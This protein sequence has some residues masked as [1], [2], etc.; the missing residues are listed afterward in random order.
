MAKGISGI[1]AMWADAKRELARV[2]QADPV[3]PHEPRDG[4]AP[5]RWPGF[6]WSRLPPGCRVHPLGIDGKVTYFVDSLGQ[7]YSVAASEW[8]KKTLLQLFAADPSFPYWAWPRWGAPTADRPSVINGLEVD[9]A[10]QCL[11]HAAGRRGMF[12]ADGRVRGR[13]A[14]LTAGGEFLWHAGETLYRVKGKA[15]EA[16]APS[17]VEGVL[18]PIRPPVTAPWSEPVGPEDS[19]AGALLATLRTWNWERPTLDPLLVLGWLGCA[20]SGGALK[21]RPHLFT[22][23]D[24]GVGKSTL[25]ALIKAILGDT[26]HAT[27]DT[28]PAGIY[29]RVKMDS[30]PC[31]IDELEASADNRRVQ[32]VVAL[33]RLASSGALMYRGGAEHSGVE[34]Q[35]RNTFVMG[36]INPPPLEPAERSRLAM[37]SLGRLDP[38][39]VAASLPDLTEDEARANITGRVILR[40]I[41]DA[42]PRWP[43]ELAYWRGVMRDNR[44][45]SRAQDTWGTLLAMAG[46]L[47]GHEAIEA[48]GLPVADPARLGARIAAETAGERAEATENWADCLGH[49]LGSTIEAWK[50]GEKPTVGGVLDDWASGAMAVREVQDRLKLVGLGAREVPAPDD[51]RSLRAPDYDGPTPPRRL[52]AVPLSAAKSPGLDRL[53]AGKKWAG[54]VW[55]S[56]LRQAPP[57]VVRRAQG[58]TDNST[59]VKINGTAQVCL[60]V[61]LAAYDDWVSRDLRG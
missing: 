27:A 53:F 32:G 24:K 45:D 59:I 51:A 61:D 60:L 3:D 33:A 40:Q 46:L 19:P 2:A 25:Q 22:T 58:R 34:F 1:R 54:G 5:G 7:F 37:L 44:M 21:W 16:R 15:L 17:E 20:F 28:T 52:L 57:D 38:T 30:L 36:A 31:A 35:L 14:W 9:D 43:A 26:L 18:Y 50:G 12:S 29:Q 13:G 41:M 56:A 8:N 6:P 11:I 10:V 48:A 42:W 39:R 47:L 55:G 23:G 49:L 4:I